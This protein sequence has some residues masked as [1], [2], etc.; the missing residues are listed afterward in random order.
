VFNHGS[1]EKRQAE[2]DN[3]QLFTPSQPKHSTN[4][5]HSTALSS[6]Q[7][8]GET[9]R[10][11]GV[12]VFA[13]RHQLRRDILVTTG[14]SESS[15]TSPDAEYGHMPIRRHVRRRL[16]APR[17]RTRSMALDPRIP[18]IFPTV[19]SVRHSLVQRRSSADRSL[20]WHSPCN[21]DFGNP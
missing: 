8:P 7:P 14:V 16:R 9:Y 20:S 19:P 21:R 13:K 11:V 2:P 17:P 6:R 15:F 18:L 10:R 3:Q 4:I 5:C 1:H 12:S